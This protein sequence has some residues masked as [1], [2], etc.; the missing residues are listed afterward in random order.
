MAT[1]GKPVF[2]IVDN[3]RVHHA[4]IVK[5]FEEQAEGRLRLLYLP[6]CSPQLNPR[7]TA[8]E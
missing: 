1:T 4:K 6:P 3:A 5:A 7:A 8:V 2:L